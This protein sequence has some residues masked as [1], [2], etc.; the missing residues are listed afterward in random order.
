MSSLPVVCALVQHVFS[1]VC[2]PVC[3]CCLLK[4]CLEARAREVGSLV[5][6]LVGVESKMKAPAKAASP[7]G[8]YGLLPVARERR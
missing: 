7:P 5:V 1:Q 2:V 3:H 8:A 4:G 6:S